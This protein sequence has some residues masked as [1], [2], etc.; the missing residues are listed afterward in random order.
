MN[1]YKQLGAKNDI[2]TIY[3]ITDMDWRGAY[4]S[5]RDMMFALMCH[6]S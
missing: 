5:A 2:K 4:V 1:I 3:Y 6:L